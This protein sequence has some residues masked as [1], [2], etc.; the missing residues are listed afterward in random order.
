MKYTI[1]TIGLFI[2]V[3]SFI[4]CRKDSVKSDTSIVGTWELRE[5]QTGMIPTIKYPAGNGNKVIFSANGYQYYSNMQL[6]KNGNYTISSDT[7]ATQGECLN[8]PAGEYVKR[9]IFDNNINA[10]KRF[11]Q[12]E[13]TLNFLSGCF[14]LDSGSY[15]SYERK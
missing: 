2:L 3:A 5:A 7:S 10:S 14:A 6:V 11:D 12:S 8:L 4:S 1:G 15:M 9:I 13:N